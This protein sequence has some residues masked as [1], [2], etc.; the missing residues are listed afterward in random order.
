MVSIPILARSAAR[1]FLSSSHSLSATRKHW[2]LNS[3]RLNG[4]VG[5][6]LF[7]A[8]YGPY[9]LISW[10]YPHGVRPNVVDLDKLYGEYGLGD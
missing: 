4:D 6:S 9:R 3:A 5:F 1:F 8:T 7:I 10:F 2:I